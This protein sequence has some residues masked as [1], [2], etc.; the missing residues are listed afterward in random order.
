MATILDHA[1]II[2]CL[3]SNTFLIGS[4]LIQPTL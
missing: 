2:S 1:T 3:N 4:L